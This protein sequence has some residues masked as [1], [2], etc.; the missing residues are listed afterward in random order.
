[1]SIS[2][3]ELFLFCKYFLDIEVYGIL[4]Y[5]NLCFMWFFF[6]LF[7]ISYFELLNLKKVIGI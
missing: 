1:M 2:D 6:F 7:L 4:K 5:Y 3:V